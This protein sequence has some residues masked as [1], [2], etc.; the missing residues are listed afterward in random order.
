[1]SYCKHIASTFSHG[2]RGR[3]NVLKSDFGISHVQRFVEGNTFC[4][5]VYG[6]Q[7]EVKINFSYLQ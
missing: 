1:M 3:K 7:S 4:F 5:L 6:K 2:F